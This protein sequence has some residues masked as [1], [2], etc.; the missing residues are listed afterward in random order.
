[1]RNAGGLFVIGA[2]RSLLRLGAAAMHLIAVS[3]CG[4]REEHSSVDLVA[5]PSFDEA[6]D[7]PC[8]NCGERDPTPDE[9]MQLDEVIST[10]VANC[11]GPNWNSIAD[12]LSNK[13]H[14]GEVLI[15][16]KEFHNDTLPG[17]WVAWWRT[18][19]PS[20]D[21]TKI[22]ISDGHWVEGTFSEVRSAYTLAHE[23]VHDF[24][25]QGHTEAFWSQFSTCYS[26]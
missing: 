9:M 10:R 14:R 12:D 18:G 22:Y 5:A 15:F 1:M 23:G 3:S 16:P 2:A 11:S 13:L 8:P 6:P 17:A 4:D 24:L 7:A 19:Q 26:Y 21:S 20:P 25:Y